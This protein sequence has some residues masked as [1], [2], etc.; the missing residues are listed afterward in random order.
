MIEL[1]EKYAEILKDYMRQDG[2]K[3]DMMKVNK[4]TAGIY[5]TKKEIQIEMGK[6]RR[7][8]LQKVASLYKQEQ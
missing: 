2:E 3:E 7:E 6:H 4:E 5:S 8:L 1:E